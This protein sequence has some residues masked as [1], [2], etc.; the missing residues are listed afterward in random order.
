[1]NINNIILLNLAKSRENFGY[2]HS[3]RALFALPWLKNKM[4]FKEKYLNEKV[5]FNDLGNAFNNV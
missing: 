4:I 1:M 3:Q 5:M 2:Q